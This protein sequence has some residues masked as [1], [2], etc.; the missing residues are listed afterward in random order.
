MSSRSAAAG[1]SAPSCWTWLS[2]GPVDVLPDH[3]ANTFAAWLQ[4]HRH[5]KMV[6]RDRGG[7]FADGANRAMSGIPRMADRWHLLHNL[8]TAVEKTSDATA[9]A[10]SNPNL[11]RTVPPRHPRKRALSSRSVPAGT[12]MA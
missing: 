12:R 11:S 4:D 5:V 2:A 6:C 9:P 1:D 8:A 10:S 3:T 7:A